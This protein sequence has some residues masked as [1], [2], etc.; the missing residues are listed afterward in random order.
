M[1]QNRSIGISN[2]TFPYHPVHQSE[3]TVSTKQWRNLPQRKA[4]SLGSGTPGFK[5][6]RLLLLLD[7]VGQVTQASS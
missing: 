6:Q 2:D 7:D 1:R 5:S 4:Q 3:L